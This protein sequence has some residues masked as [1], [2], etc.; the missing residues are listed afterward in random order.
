MIIDILGTPYEVIKK[1]FS[2]DPMFEK[3]CIQAYCDGLLHQI[4][5]CDPAT[6]KGWEKES[7]EYISIQEKLV[8]RHEIIHAFLNESGLQDAALEHNGGWAKNEEMI[9]W[10]AIQGPK[11][12]TVWQEAGAIQ[13]GTEVVRC[14]NCKK[15]RTSMCAAKHERADM[16][17]CSTGQAIEQGKRGRL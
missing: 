3:H 5:Y 16:D 14:K 8:L 4:V 15:F 11:I 9:D 13:T 12:Y 10:F 1:T 2:D 6:Y 17:Y 7:A